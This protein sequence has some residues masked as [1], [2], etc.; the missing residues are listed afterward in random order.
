MTWLISAKSL[1][2]CKLRPNK[3]VIKWIIL[4]GHVKL[5]YMLIQ[6]DD[7]SSLEYIQSK[8][9]KKKRT[10]SLI[11]YLIS[12]QHDILHNKNCKLTDI[13]LRRMPVVQKRSFVLS[14]LNN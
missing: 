2:P 11:K 6:Y 10:V 12:E 3:K 13:I 14:F 1:F 5:Y 7:A 9:E 8:E 4:S